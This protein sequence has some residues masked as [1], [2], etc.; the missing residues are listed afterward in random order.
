MKAIELKAIRELPETYIVDG[1]Q[2]ATHKQFVIAINGRVP[3]AP[4]QWM[5]GHG[6]REM[7]FEARPGL[8]GIG[9]IIS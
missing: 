8:G 6:W 5:E 3:L 1:T 9:V 2:I 7:K 4:I